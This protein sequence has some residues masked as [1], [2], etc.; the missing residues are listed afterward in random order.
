MSRM[1]ALRTIRTCNFSHEKD[2]PEVTVLVTPGV[3][4]AMTVATPADSETD[5]STDV[6]TQGVK[7]ENAGGCTCKSSPFESDVKDVEATQ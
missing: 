2:M 4:S 5:V 3:T 7:N 6:A 1:Q